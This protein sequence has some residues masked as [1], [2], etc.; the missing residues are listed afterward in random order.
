MPTVH[1]SDA[2]KGLVDPPYPCKAGEMISF[3]QTFAVTAAIAGALADVIEMVPIPPNCRVSDI[4]IDTDELDDGADAILVDVGVMSGAWGVKD[5]ERTCGDEFLD[6]SNIAQAGGVARPVLTSAFRVAPT[7][8]ARSI[9][10][11][12]ATAANSGAAGTIGI[13]VQ[14]AA[15]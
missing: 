2:A 7:D 1:Q 13:T 14:Y 10:V 9:G 11:K 4:I 6:G 12:I 15:A 5:D 3:R 8:T